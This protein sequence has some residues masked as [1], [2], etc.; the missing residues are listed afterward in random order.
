LDV[1]L[2]V[3]DRGASCCDVSQ[4]INGRFEPAGRQYNDL[5][6]DAGWPSTSVREIGRKF[7][8]FDHA[9]KFVRSQKPVTVVVKIESRDLVRDP[10]MG[11]AAI[12]QE[13]SAISRSFGLK[14]AATTLMQ[15]F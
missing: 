10:D 13:K 11:A 9:Q 1:L 3:S 6:A 12:T 5:V 15:R 4:S 8:S 7:E 14:I 2:A